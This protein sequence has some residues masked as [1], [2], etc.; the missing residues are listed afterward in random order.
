MHKVQRYKVYALNTQAMETTIHL[1][2]QTQIQ[3]FK[4]SGQHSGNA[5]D[6]N[7]L[8]AVNL[9]PSVSADQKITITFI[10]YNSCQIFKTSLTII[11][12]KNMLSLNPQASINQIE[13]TCLTTI[14]SFFLLQIKVG[15][16]A[17]VPMQSH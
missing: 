15:P 6:I 5:D 3:F 10:V 8:L 7:D 4:S 17:A 11:T 12:M 13:L 2:H 14:L 1:E 9:L 16:S